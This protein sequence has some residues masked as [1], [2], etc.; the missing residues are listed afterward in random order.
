MEP[1]PP[2]PDSNRRTLQGIAPDPVKHLSEHSIELYVLKRT[3]FDAATRSFMQEHLKACPVCAEIERD[4]R[5][6]HAEIHSSMRSTSSRVQVVGEKASPAEKI[7][8]LYPYKHFSNPDAVDN[9]Y[10]AVLAAHSPESFP[11]RFKPV[12]VYSSPDQ[13]IVVRILQDTDADLYKLYVLAEKQDGC[14]FA[15]VSFPELQMDLG[16][17]ESGRMDFSLPGEQKPSDWHKLH[18]FVR[19]RQQNTTPP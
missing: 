3:I 11:Y 12:A 13:E 18:V 1:S 2:A 7:I 17:D 15:V 16:T 5:T 8:P 19:L 10:V 14:R 6:Y 4:L 9:R